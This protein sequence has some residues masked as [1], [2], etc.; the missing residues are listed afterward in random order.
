MYCLTSSGSVSACQ[1]ASG[2]ALIVIC[3]SAT[4]EP[5]TV[6]PPVMNLSANLGHRTSRSTPER[7]LGDD[8]LR[9][10]RGEL[11]PRRRPL[12]P[13]RCALCAVTAVGTLGR[14]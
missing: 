3:F 12:L 1:T 14:R 13:R 4:N 7:G 2:E 8:L 5:F 6:S 10:Q 9:P 11:H